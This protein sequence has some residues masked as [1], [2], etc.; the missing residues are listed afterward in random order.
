MQR[1]C[2]RHRE[3]SDAIQSALLLPSPIARRYAPRIKTILYRIYTATTGPS[4]LLQPRPIEA[5]IHL[6]VHKGNRQ[7]RR[8]RVTISKLL[9]RC[10]KGEPRINNS[11]HIN[12]LWHLFGRISRTK[13]TTSPGLDRS[14]SAHCNAEKRPKISKIENPV[15][16]P[17]QP[18]SPSI[19]V[20][21]PEWTQN[22][23]ETSSAEIADKPSPP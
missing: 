22:S 1:T 4:R 16:L 11:I 5:G 10:L 2:F 18:E 13:T 21:P 7:Q 23:S 17:V 6:N 3:Q 14:Y 19:P 12:V 8:S 9:D 15:Y 20:D